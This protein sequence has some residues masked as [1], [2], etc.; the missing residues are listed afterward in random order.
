MDTVLYYRVLRQE[1]DHL[2]SQVREHDTGH[3]RTAISV[4]IDRL[5]ELKSNMSDQE[6]FLLKMSMHEQDLV[7]D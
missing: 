7:R 2:Q 1:V 5:L 4:L 6:K 3:I